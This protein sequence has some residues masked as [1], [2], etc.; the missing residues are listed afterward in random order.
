M[1]RFEVKKDGAD[2][3]LLSFPPEAIRALADHLMAIEQ[4]HGELPALMQ[5]PIRGEFAL[6]RES[7]GTFDDVLRAMLIGSDSVACATA[8]SVTP[9]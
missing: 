3:L 7:T 2:M 8:G 6:S 4:A 5:I 9:S 1:H